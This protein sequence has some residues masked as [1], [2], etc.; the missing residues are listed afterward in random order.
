M[1]ETPSMKPGQ[2]VAIDLTVPDA[3]AVRDFYRALAGW[4]SAPVAMG[5][6]D[7]YHM[8]SGDSGQPVAGICH[9]RG[10]NKDQ[11]PVWMIYI[12]V[13]SVEA[14]VARCRELGGTVLISPRAETGHAVA[15]LRDPAGAIFS[16]YQP[17][18]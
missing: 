16:V 3:D 6:Y 13:E 10:P 2:I 7:D 14:A 8:L 18:A 12:A 5:D 4:E 17:P 15:V 11:P 9:A 1:S